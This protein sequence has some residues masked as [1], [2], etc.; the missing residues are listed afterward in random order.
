MKFT[1][2]Q[3]WKDFRNCKRAYRSLVLFVFL[4][5]F[6]SLAEL[7]ANDKPYI[8]KLD[9]QYYFPIFE[10]ITERDLGGVFPVQANFNDPYWL[11]I[12]EQR[13]FAFFPP[14]R[15]GNTT[16][17][18]FSPSAAPSPPSFYNYLGTDDA[19]RDVMARLIYSMRISL[20]FSL[21]ITVGSVLIGILIGSVQG[22]FGGMVDLL[23]Q[24]FTEIW[25]NLPVLYIIIILTSILMP[26]I[27]WLFLILLVFSWLGV[28]QVV[29]AEFLK[30]RKTEYVTAA[31]LLGVSSIRI[32]IKHIL[33]NAMVATFSF[34]PFIFISA[35]TALTSLDFL[36][37][38]LPVG[39]PS[40]GEMLAQARNNIDA[41]WISIPVTLSLASVLTLLVLVGEGIRDA[42]DPRG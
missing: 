10:R 35:M 26:N 25:S 1:Q 32:M 21:L 13:G 29:R 7:I 30:A 33:P 41:Y 39:S 18:V 4:F 5:C 2:T 8:L 40:I 28:A 27:Y 23:M 42:L 9:G 16:V 15:F 36:G 6:V 3:A 34:L 14:I 22:Y 12:I 20:Y 31:R 24:R 11:E 38:G 19:G 37:L 17:D